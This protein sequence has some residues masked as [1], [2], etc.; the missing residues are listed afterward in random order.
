MST[1]DDALLE[2]QRR[3]ELEMLRQAH[4]HAAE[5]AAAQRF[6][7]ECAE[8]ADFARQL[9]EDHDIQKA[10]DQQKANI[11]HERRCA[12]IRSDMERELAEERV[13]IQARLVKR[14]ELTEEIEKRG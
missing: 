8:L 5:E 1:I 7:D 3:H 4:A 14:G 6:Q 9:L 11:D 2:R 12:E 10:A 13:R